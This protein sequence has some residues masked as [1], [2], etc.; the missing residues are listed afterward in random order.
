MP[1]PRTNTPTFPLGRIVMTAN[2]ARRLTPREIRDALRRH[3]SGDWGNAGAGPR[4]A[5]VRVW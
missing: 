4:P 1:S 2:A 3:E 5:L